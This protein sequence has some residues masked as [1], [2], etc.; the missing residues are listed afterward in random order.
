MKEE[1]PEDRAWKQRA[2]PILLAAL[3]RANA[4][5]A[6]L[7]AAFNMSRVEM[8]PD[9]ETTEDE[10]RDTVAFAMDAW[11]SAEEILKKL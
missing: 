9:P 11:G 8:A 5:I 7:Y 1:S 4:A 10:I 6:D 3:L 2:K